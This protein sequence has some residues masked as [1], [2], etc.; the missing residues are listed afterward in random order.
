VG[1]H[2]VISDGHIFHPEFRCDHLGQLEGLLHNGEATEAL[3]VGKGLANSLPE[4]SPQVLVPLNL[5]NQI[6][7][8][9]PGVL[10]LPVQPD[11]G[12][13]KRI[14]KA[15]DFQLIR[16]TGFKRVE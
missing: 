5:S 9:D 14:R 7:R 15:R 3:Q 12:Q 10:V 1:F 4:E 13:S 11:P 16:F 2:P 6:E 8:N